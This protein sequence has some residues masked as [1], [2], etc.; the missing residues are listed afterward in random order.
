[1][2]TVKFVNCRVLT[3]TEESESVTFGRSILSLKSSEKADKILDLDGA[4][5]V[6]GFIDSHAHLTNAEVDTAFPISNLDRDSTIRRIMSGNPNYGE[7][8]ITRGWDESTWKDKR[9]I[10][11]SELESKFPIMA[12]RVDGHM[13]VL[14][15]KGAQMAREMGLRVDDNNIIKEDDEFKLRNKIISENRNFNS[16]RKIE[17]LC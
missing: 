13:A 9:F 3:P 14:N 10:L 2:A 6:P 11:S 8:L 1:M 12:I 4:L 16:L 17:D 15:T 5:V 7:W